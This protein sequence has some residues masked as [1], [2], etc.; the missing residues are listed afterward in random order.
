MDINDIQKI[1]HNHNL[2]EIKTI[3]EKYLSNLKLLFQ[4]I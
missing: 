4:M 1:A 3:K 2:Q